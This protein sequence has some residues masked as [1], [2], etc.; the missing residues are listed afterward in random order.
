MLDLCKSQLVKA[1]AQVLG[2]IWN[3]VGLLVCNIT[4]LTTLIKKLD[5]ELAKVN[6]ESLYRLLDFYRECVPAFT[7]LFELLHQILGQ[8][9]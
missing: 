1:T 4:K 5:G 2:Y 9:A 8:D 6:R 3:L 7:E